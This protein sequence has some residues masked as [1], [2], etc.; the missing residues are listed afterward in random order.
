[1]TGFSFGTMV[2]F[3]VP[4]AEPVPDYGILYARAGRVV[5][6]YDKG[7][8]QESRVVGLR[9]EYLQADECASLLTY[10]LM[11]VRSN[12]FTIDAGD[13]LAR[14][15][16]WSPRDGEEVQ[17]VYQVRLASEVL[18]V[19]HMGGELWGVGLRVRKV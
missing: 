3:P 17:G 16:L 5:R 15:G 14:M 18:E 4:I 13:S 7:Q 6:E 19:S 8:G 9:W 11:Q 10:I 1:V 2:N 12:T